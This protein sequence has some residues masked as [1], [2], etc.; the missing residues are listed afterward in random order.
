MTMGSGWSEKEWFGPTESTT[1][2][3]DEVLREEKFKIGACTER[4]GGVDA[5]VVLW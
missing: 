4:L 2:F 3:P 5:E 1:A